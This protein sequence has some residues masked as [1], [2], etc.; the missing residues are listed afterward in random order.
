MN[1]LRAALTLLAALA[2]LAGGGGARA[3]TA[4]TEQ[5][6]KAAFLYKFPAFVEWPQRPAEAF[7]IAVAGADEIAAEL[8]RVG[9]GREIL[10]R[11]I[12][13]KP[14][15]EGESPA[16]AQVLFVG[17]DSARLAQLARGVAGTPVLVVSESA[18]ALEQGSILNFVIVDGRVRFEVALDA[19]ERNG[20]RISPRLLALATRVRPARP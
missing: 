14:L 11:P 2:C 16:G 4:A 6:V 7:V 8:A 15:R 3:Q 13:V 5:E 1:G 19:A 20:L 18:G 17:R 9:H 12:V 10:G